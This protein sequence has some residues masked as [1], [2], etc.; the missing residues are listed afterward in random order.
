[1][2][3][4]SIGY[5]VNSRCLLAVIDCTEICRIAATIALYE[6][7]RYSGKDIDMD[8]ADSKIEE[9]M[10]AYMTALSPDE[11][12][13]VL[14][15]H[16]ALLLSE[17]VHAMLEDEIAKEYKIGDNKTARRLEMHMRLFDVA[18]IRGIDPAW[19]RFHAQLEF[20]K[21][22]G[23]E[24][25]ASQMKQ[26]L[27]E[28]SE[29]T[30]AFLETASSHW[31]VSYLYAKKHPELLRDEVDFILQNLTMTA[32]AMNDAFSARTFEGHRELLQ[33][34]REI[35]VE[36]AYAEKLGMSLQELNAYVTR[37]TMPAEV[38][39]VIDELLS[40]APDN[41]TEEIWSQL[42]LE[43]PDLY[44]RLV[45]AERLAEVEEPIPPE[46]QKR[47]A[48]AFM[49]E[50]GAQTHPMDTAIEQVLD[51]WMSIYR[52]SDF[53]SAPDSVQVSVLDGIAKALSQRYDV[54]KHP[55]D[56]DDAIRYW[57]ETI[58]LTSPD[59]PK[60]PQLLS[61][62]SDCLSRRYEL[63]RS[64]EDLEALIA[65]NQEAV[66]TTPSNSPLFPTLLNNLGLSLY[67]R[68]ERFE[69]I[70]DLKEAIFC[71]ETALHYA[72][73]TAY[74]RVNYLT[75]L[76]NAKRSLYNHTGGQ[77]IFL[78]QA[79][80]S[81]KE[82]LQIVHQDDPAIA[83][84][85]THLGNGL[86]DL[87]IQERKLEDLEE[88]IRNHIQAVV[89]ALPDAP[90]MN[91]YLTNVAIGLAYRYQ[92]VGEMGNLEQ[93]IEIFQY[94]LDHTPSDSPDFPD[95]LIN[96][97]T[98]L[99]DRYDRLEEL[100]DLERSIAYVRRAIDLV[101][102][103]NNLPALADYLAKLGSTLPNLYTHV[104][105]EEYLKEAL[106]VT[107]QALRYTP[108]GSLDLLIRLNGLATILIMRYDH[109]GILEDLNEAIDLLETALSH[110]SANATILLQTY[111]VLSEGLK[112]RY[113]RTR[114]IE[115]IRQAINY[116]RMGLQQLHPSSTSFPLYLGNL[117]SALRIYYLHTK[118]P[119]D[120]NEAI[121][122]LEQATQNIPVRTPGWA[123]ALNYLGNCLRD[124][125]KDTK[126]PEDLDRSIATLQETERIVQ[127]DIPTR[128]IV[129]GDLA[130]SLQL[131]Y[132]RIHQP[133]DLEEAKK[134]YQEASQKGKLLAPDIALRSAYDWGNW[135]TEREEWDEAAEAYASAITML[136]QLYS[137][138]LLRASQEAMLSN[139]RSL[140]AKAAYAQ[141]RA[142]HLKEAVVT[143][144]QGRARNLSQVLAR[145]YA[146]LKQLQQEHPE[147]YDQYQQAAESLR[148]LE[149]VERRND[150]LG[151]QA[152]SRLESRISPRAYARSPRTDGT[153]H[154]RYPANSWL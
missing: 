6:G 13:R 19:Q 5:V 61:S 136:E 73:E 68:Y 56:L 76:G 54:Y 39:E 88:G 32:K 115:D 140:H 15:E 53:S 126:N 96:L 79:I 48:Q 77:I 2:R 14:K 49:A 138:Q 106:E 104:G 144:E 11:A 17:R 93:A 84:C 91:D 86:A 44:Q 141:A 30:R 134:A 21:V 107:Q 105:K 51:S 7:D 123:G 92:Y 147:M 128:P 146:N 120:L 94:V 148:E 3:M 12:Y 129:V 78:R 81:Y 50:H 70:E 18:H 113:N 109:G 47:L 132:E 9:V 60:R 114:D 43:H 83:A 67:A 143:L 139:V 102:A 117:G 125:Y 137:T 99:H 110:P 82:A 25:A 36:E 24:E 62:M 4:P 124:R 35:G 42:L 41:L 122:V 63:S 130:L 121:E 85:F 90:A 103:Q 23:R 150:L 111:Q 98:A 52:Q 10:R 20:V 154:C 33:R 45:V 119:E 142:G 64:V 80:E 100:G 8:V 87:F 65:H 29:I 66:D 40:V 59:S 31:P 118:R 145:D 55:A 72:P 131:R 152:R 69:T 135:A 153:G 149:Q 26:R 112:R 75:N 28:L 74:E 108:Q 57:N 16:Q 37:E 1:M 133:E 95:Y 22:P 127:T 46:L 151:V 101:R 38:R 27:A 58:E 97:A 71:Y 34:C 116:L 89:H